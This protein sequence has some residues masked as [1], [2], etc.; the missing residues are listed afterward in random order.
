MAKDKDSIVFTLNT[1]GKRGKIKN[2]STCQYWRKPMGIF[3]K[4]QWCSNSRSFFCMT[5]TQSYNSCF[6][7]VESGK[8]APLWMRIVNKVLRKA[9]ER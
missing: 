3:T 5:C 1:E 7:Y 9:N 8:K 6:D 2:C 4:G